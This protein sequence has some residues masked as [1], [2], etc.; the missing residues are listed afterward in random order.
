M[1]QI[2]IQVLMLQR[3]HKQTTLVFQKYLLTSHAH[4]K[5]NLNCYHQ[6]EIL[7]AYSCPVEVLEGI[8]NF[9]APEVAYQSTH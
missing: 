6:E 3:I 7:E 4:L 2:E 9:L 8:S 5:K 1:S